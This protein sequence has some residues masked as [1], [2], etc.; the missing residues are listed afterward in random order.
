[1]L[2]ASM[3]GSTSRLAGPLRVELGII[4]ARESGSSATSPC[5]SPSTSSQGACS[6]NSSSV[7]RIL[8]A[9][10]SSLEPKL[11]CDSRA[12]LGCRPKRSISSAAMTVISLSSSAVGS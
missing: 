6:R 12:A 5:I 10:G 4:V 1:M 11:E 3:L 7:R 8:M 9:L 2:A